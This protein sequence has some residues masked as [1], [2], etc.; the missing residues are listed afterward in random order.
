MALV[1][2]RDRAQITLP[3][4]LRAALKVREGDYFEA[5]I[6]DGR[7][8]L[9]PVSVVSREAARERLL[10]RLDRKAPE[11]GADD[12]LLM[13][14]VVDVIKRTRRTHRESGR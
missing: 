12:D 9:E 14:E 7:L 2:L 4:E 11:L 5:E 13:D 6:V 10:E 1:R 8:V 3:Q